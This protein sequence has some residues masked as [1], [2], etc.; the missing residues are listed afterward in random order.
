VTKHIGIAAVSGPGAALCHETICAEAAAR[1]GPY[2]H[3]EITLH[4]FSFAE[5]V[6]LME[7]GDWKG[8]AELL[9]AS[10][11]K[12]AATGV[13]FAICPDNSTHIAF[14]H[15]GDRSP[16]PW[17]HIAEAVAAE[18]RARGFAR[19]GVLGTRWLVES[20][21]YPEPLAAAGLA[22]RLPAPHERARVDRIILDD[23]VYAR[24]PAEARAAVVR[25]IERLR[26]EEGCDAVILGCT[27][28]PLLVAPEASPLP[29]LDST[30]LLARAAI[31]R[32]LD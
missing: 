8:V 4:A 28:L 25:V 12:L 17:L 31:G 13:D 21:V 29:V 14:P 24:F 27:E 2:A 1:L 16:I 10:A 15:L 5:H 11:R 22:W 30:R 32:A 7:R 6:L 18:A 19:L 23:L 20:D 9:L 26:A 3:P